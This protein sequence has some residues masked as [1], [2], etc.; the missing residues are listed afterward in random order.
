VSQLGNWIFRAGVIYEA[1]NKAHGSVAVLTAAVLVV[2]LPILIGSR[3]LAPLVDRWDTRRVLVSLDAI[4]ALILCGLLIG[5]L[6]RNDLITPLAVTTL[7]LLCLLS[8]MFTASQTAYLRRV[9]PADGMTGALAGLSKVEWA[10]FILGTAAGPILL[11]LSDVP[12]LI[13][14]DAASF[15][16]SATLLCR[17]RPA[18]PITVLTSSEAAVQQ[19]RLD[20]QTKRIMLSVWVINAGAGLINVYPN[21]VTRDFLH[22]DARLLGLINLIDG[23]GGL[24]GATVVGRWKPGVKQRPILL[25]ALL[26][27]ISL[28]G[29][30]GARHLSLALVASATMLLAGQIY[31]VSAQARMLS[32]DPARLAGRI[33]GYFRFATLG[34]VTVS[35]LA[36]PLA[37]HIAGISIGFPVLLVAAAAL[38]LLAAFLVR[39]VRGTQSNEPAIAG[40]AVPPLTVGAPTSGREPTAREVAQ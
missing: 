16:L 22:G 36:F 9:L 10:T 3:T 33:S 31:S 32:N 27:S 24:V 23:F 6:Y 11:Q 1:Y 17:L 8:P 26:V 40:M 2:Y 14:V 7:G 13:L 19:P 5:V 18:P 35:T 30:V 39:D 34:G 4:R 20:P 38:A 29:M 12:Q 25:G 15:V 21:V 28:V 37:V